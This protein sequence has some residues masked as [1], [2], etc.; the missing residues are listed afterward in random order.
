[1]GRLSLDAR[2]EAV[3]F[4]PDRTAVLV[5]DMQNDFGSS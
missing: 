4:D 2:P 1:M 3:T 5:T